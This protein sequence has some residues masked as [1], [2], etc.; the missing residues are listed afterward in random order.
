MLSQDYYAAKYHYY[1]NLLQN[2]Q[3]IEMGTHCKNIVIRDYTHPTSKSPYSEHSTTS[4]IGEKLLP[5]AQKY[6]EIKILT[7]KL[8]DILAH[9]SRESIQIKIKPMVHN[10]LPITIKDILKP[11]SNYIE[12][13]SEYIHKGIQMRSRFEISV[14]TI[15]DSLNLEYYYEPELIINGV[16]YYPDFIV[17]LPELGYCFIIEC[18]GKTQDMKYMY[19]NSGKIL[20]YLNY[21]LETNKNLLIFSGTDKYIPP[22][23]YMRTEIINLINFIAKEVVEYC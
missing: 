14:A 17:F 21:G 11:C 12:I 2:M 20:T 7:K 13:D 9:Q 3:R 18:L 6:E 16:I 15:L 4:S 22:I 10:I 8:R 5:Y 19:N 1:K 23:D